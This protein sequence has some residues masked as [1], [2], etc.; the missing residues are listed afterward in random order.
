[1]TISEA[2]DH[3]NSLLTAIC[4]SLHI[5]SA[6]YLRLTTFIQSCKTHNEISSSHLLAQT[7]KCGKETL[8]PLIVYLTVPQHS[9]S[10]LA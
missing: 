5:E 4:A 1:M 2:H 3:Q 7:L 6:F 10:Q 8:L 9:P